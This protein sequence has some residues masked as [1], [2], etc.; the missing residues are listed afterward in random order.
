MDGTIQ[1][2]LVVLC[3]LQ[4]AVI[5]C[6]SEQLGFCGVHLKDHKV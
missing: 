2:Y 1:V 6:K 5:I 3:N 4:L